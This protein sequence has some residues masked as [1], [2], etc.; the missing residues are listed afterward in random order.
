MNAGKEGKRRF[1]PGTKK[2][3]L[4]RKKIKLEKIR[5]LKVWLCTGYMHVHNKVQ[6]YVLY[7][8][9]YENCA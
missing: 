2:N 9:M 8:V 4:E 7:F 6:I 3:H 5:F 1:K